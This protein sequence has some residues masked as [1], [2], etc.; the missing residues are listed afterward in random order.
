[1]STT[2]K[3]H[4]SAAE[5]AGMTLEGLPATKKGM[6]EFAERESWPRQ[7]RVGR[8]GGFEYQPPEAIMAQIRERAASALLQQAAT[9]PVSKTVQTL[10]VKT[11]LRE[12]QLALPLPAAKCRLRNAARLAR[13][14]PR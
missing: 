2:V 5:L 4:Y 7:K 6:I 1:M 12:A 3:T 10:P 9:M 14:E 11:A 13:R 8:G